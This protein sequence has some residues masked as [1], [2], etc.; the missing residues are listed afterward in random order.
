V[1]L[2][3]FQLPNSLF[4][5]ARLECPSRVFSCS[6]LR[7]GFDSD[8]DEFF[9][10]YPFE[11]VIPFFPRPSSTFGSSQFKDGLI[12]KDIPATGN[13]NKFAA[14]LVLKYQRSDPLFP[15]IVE[16]ISEEELSSC[17]LSFA[18]KLL[19][20]NGSVCPSI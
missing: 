15:Q 7:D 19:D 20:S 8:C 18:G 10:R 17:E 11:E 4:G 2:T 13:P 14:V 9:P 5:A 6:V 16:T 12:F 1:S 3:P